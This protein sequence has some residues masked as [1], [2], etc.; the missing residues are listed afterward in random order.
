[1]CFFEKFLPPGYRSSSQSWAFLRR[2]LSGQNIFL[3]HRRSVKSFF[4]IYHW[5]IWTDPKNVGT[6]R[7]E[8][9]RYLSY[10]VSMTLPSWR[11]WS[12]WKSENISCQ[13]RRDREVESEHQRRERLTVFRAESAP[14]VMAP[15]GGALDMSPEAS[16]TSHPGHDLSVDHITGNDW[17][18]QWLF[19]VS[20]QIGF[21]YPGKWR[22]NSFIWYVLVL[23]L[24]PKRSQISL[25]Q[26]SW[27]LDMRLSEAL[28][29]VRSVGQRR[30]ERN[31]NVWWQIGRVISCFSTGG[32]YV[33]KKCL[34]PS[35]CYF[36]GNVF[37]RWSSQQSARQTSPVLICRK[38]FC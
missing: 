35:M 8:N 36:E 7:K 9:W 5:A 26:N 20:S 27:L 14:T 29:W 4:L 13:V 28:L 16:Q 21:S 19:L 3:F 10:F 11:K 18:G 17:L 12:V 32:I 33:D 15:G 37:L 6:L 23:A 2:T 24:V 25:R 30:T 1:M 38:V 34:Y 22:S 31:V